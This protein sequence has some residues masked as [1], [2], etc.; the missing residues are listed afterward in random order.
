[1]LRLYLFFKRNVCLSFIQRMRRINVD[2]PERIRTGRQSVYCAHL[3]CSCIWGKYRSEQGLSCLVMFT[4]KTR[5]RPM[6]YGKCALA[7]SEVELVSK[8]CRGISTSTGAA[9]TGTMVFQIKT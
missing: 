5:R 6:V 8:E 3:L 9:K 1:M 4:I 7:S 2:G